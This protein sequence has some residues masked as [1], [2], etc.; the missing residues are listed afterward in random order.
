MCFSF[1]CGNGRMER[2][3]N[4]GCAAVHS[5]ISTKQRIE[6][7]A[8]LSTRAEQV[9]SVPGPTRSGVQAIGKLNQRL[10]SRQ[11]SGFREITND[12]R[13]CV[14]ESVST[15]GGLITWTRSRRSVLVTEGLRPAK[16]H[17]SDPG[18]LI[19]FNDLAWAF[20]P[21]AATWWSSSTA[22]VGR[23]PAKWR[24]RSTAGE[25]SRLLIRSTSGSATEPTG[26]VERAGDAAIGSPL[27]VW[28]KYDLAEHSAFAQHLVRVTR[29]FERQPL[30]DQGLDL[31]FFEQVQ[32]R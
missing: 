28:Q 12:K 9:I 26:R 1:R 11:V 6:R 18:R 5:R 7:P 2:R 23:F 16:V 10:P 3:T 29:L 21:V 19:F 8:I 22:R 25:L 4:R 14:Y 13:R 27:A 32:Q 24:D 15:V 17:E 20:D 31:A 30:R